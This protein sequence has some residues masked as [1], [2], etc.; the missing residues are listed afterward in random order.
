MDIRENDD[1]WELLFADDLAIIA[2]TEEGL[3]QR[4]LIWKGNLERKGMKVNTQK[5]EVMV[6]SREGHEEISV[7]SEDGRRLKQTNEFKYLGSV[8][9]D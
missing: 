6:S 9:A 8:I 5:T 3:Q 4:Y 2:D 1:L 7:T